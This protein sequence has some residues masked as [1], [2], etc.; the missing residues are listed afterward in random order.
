MP[1]EEACIHRH[2]LLILNWRLCSTSHSQ[3]QCCPSPQPITSSQPD[4]L[5]NVPQFTTF[6]YII[7]IRWCSAAIGRAM[8]LRF[9]GRGSTPGC[10]PL[11][12]GLGQASYTCVSVTKQYNLV[13]AKGVI[14]LAGKVTAVLVESNGSLPPGFWLS[15][16]WADCQETGISSMPDAC[17]Q[18]WD[19]FL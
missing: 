12:S 3:C 5:C 15:H 11:R 18:V 14:S 19:Y 1:C 13:P 6:S 8:D 17:N 2:R 16:L 4:C 7:S 10:A 9:T